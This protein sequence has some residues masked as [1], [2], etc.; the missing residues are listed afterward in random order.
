MT[1]DAL[2]SLGHRTVPGPPPDLGER[3]T[4]RNVPLGGPRAM[5]VRRTL[6]Q[7]TRSLIGPWCFVDHFGPDDVSANGGMAVPRHPHTGLA[8]VTLLFSGQVLHR[9]STGFTNTVRPGEVNL[10]IAGRGISH[11][12]FSTPD[13]TRLHGIQL[14]YALPDDLRHGPPEAQHHVPTPEIR[15]GG[16]VR[17]YVGRI[18]GACSPIDTRTP[19][20]AAEALIN[21]GESLDLPLDPNC[22]HGLLLDTGSVSLTAWEADGVEASART[23]LSPGALHYLPAGLPGV[24][25]HARPGPGVRVVIVGGPPFD[26]DIVLWWNFVARSHAEIVAYRTQWQREIGAEPGPAPGPVR[27]GPYPSEPSGAL[28]A[29]EL[30]NAQIRPRT[31]ARGQQ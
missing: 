5:T 24:R 15:P 20:H 7:R 18:A 27:F 28:P 6:P 1:H 2:N 11:S 31:R 17:T 9:D 10:M 19:A 3:L 23:A 8:T 12:E 29:P 13:T 26:E 16:T 4:P 22:E 14:W 30:P 21:P 25:V